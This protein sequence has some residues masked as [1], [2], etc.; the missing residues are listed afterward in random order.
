MVFGIFGADTNDTFSTSG[1][2]LTSPGGL[3]KWSKWVSFDSS[4]YGESFASFPVS[5]S[6]KISELRRF[7]RKIPMFYLF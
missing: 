7:E 4:C 3:I 2:D 6:L 1:S 5:L